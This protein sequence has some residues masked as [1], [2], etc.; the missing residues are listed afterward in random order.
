LELH[1]EITVEKTE[2]NITVAVVGADT[3]PVTENLAYRAADTVLEACN[4]PFGVHIQLKKSIPVQ[5]GLGGGSSDGAATLLAVNKLAGNVV[6][7]DQIMLF[8]AELGSDV[9]FFASG[10]AFAVGRGRG[11]RI[12][13]VLGPSAVPA[14]IVLPG[15]GVR[16]REAYES[17]AAKRLGR[18]LPGAPKLSESG[19]V[20][21]SEIQHVSANDFEEVLFET[22]L[23][24]REYFTRLQQTGPMLTRLCGSGSAIIAIYA[25]AAERDGATA[26]FRDAQQVIPTGIRA[27]PASEPMPA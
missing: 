17:L 20:G 26:E 19:F 6:P 27:A 23:R 22:E 3:G 9:P 7:I 12:F 5:A 2:E 11:E 24:L 1:D 14:L 8:A 16:T 13:E 4:R 21:W 15:F 25:S 18:E 10:A